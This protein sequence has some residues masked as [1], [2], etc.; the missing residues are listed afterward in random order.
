MIDHFGWSYG[1]DDNAEALVASVD[2]M[3]GHVDMDTMESWRDDN[4]LAIMKGIK[5]LPPK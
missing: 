3:A 5:P 1:T 2:N 4:L